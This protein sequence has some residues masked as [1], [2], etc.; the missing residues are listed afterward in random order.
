MPVEIGSVVEAPVTKILGYGALVS[1]PDGQS[2]LVHISE[3]ADA[4]V[5]DVADWLRVGEVVKVKVVN[6]NDRGRYELSLKQVE[7]RTPINPEALQGGP[8]RRGRGDSGFEERL[9]D[10]MKASQRRLGDLKRNRESKL[11]RRRRR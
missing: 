4:Y 11:R 3:I 2:G 7:K 5:R 8:P 1:L 6:I 10:F 9:S